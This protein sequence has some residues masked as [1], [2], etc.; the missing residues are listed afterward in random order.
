[1]AGTHLE[2]P[3]ARGQLPPIMASLCPVPR[4]LTA[5]REVVPSPDLTRGGR[6]PHRR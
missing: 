2:V 4:A 3:V 6:F 5:S 1:M